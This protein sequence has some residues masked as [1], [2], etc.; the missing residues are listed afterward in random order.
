MW[1][2]TKYNLYK[3]LNWAYFYPDT[4]LSFKTTI[5]WNDNHLIWIFHV[6]FNMLNGQLSIHRPRPLTSKFKN[7]AK[8]TEFIYYLVFMILCMYLRTCDNLYPDF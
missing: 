2:K 8:I 3:L 6:L 7:I 1:Y 4:N 5:L